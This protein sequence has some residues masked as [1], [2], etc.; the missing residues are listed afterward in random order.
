MHHT[1]NMVIWRGFSPIIRIY[2][3]DRW[4]RYIIHGILMAHFLI[5]LKIVLVVLIIMFLKRVVLFRHRLFLCTYCSSFSVRYLCQSRVVLCLPLNLQFFM[6]FPLIFW[7]K[8]LTTL[9]FISVISSF[10]FN[11]I[12]VLIISLYSFFSSLWI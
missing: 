1:S 9:L 7:M 10:G 2:T 4:Q 6:I 3:F 11:L 5:I 12:I 8:I